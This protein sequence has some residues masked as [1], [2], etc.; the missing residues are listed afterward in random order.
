MKFQISRLK[1]RIT[2]TK[3]YQKKKKKCGGNDEKIELSQN[4]IIHLREEC[5]SKNQLL[6]ILE[7]VFESDIPKVTTYT[8]SNTL[9]TQNDDYQFPPSW[10]LHFK[11]NNRSTRTRCEICSKLTIKTPERCQCSRFGV[12]IVNFKHISHLV[13]V[14]LLLPLSR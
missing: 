4:Q 5:S 6:L 14:L 7:N 12:F 13:L 1:L 2:V 9:L 3:R 8:N 11:V 10:Q